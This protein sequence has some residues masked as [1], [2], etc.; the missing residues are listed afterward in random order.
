MPV[1]SYHDNLTG[2]SLLAPLPYP[3]PAI[4]YLLSDATA[5]TEPKA[6][7]QASPLIKIS[8]E[9]VDGDDNPVSNGRLSIGDMGNFM[10]AVLAKSVEGSP[11]KYEFMFPRDE[12]TGDLK[13]RRSMGE[14]AFYQ[15]NRNHPPVAAEAIVLG[16][17]QEDLPTIRVVVRK[18]AVLIVKAR[19][20]DGNEPAAQ[21]HVY[22][23]YGSGTKNRIEAAG[24]ANRDPRAHFTPPQMI[25]TYPA[26]QTWNPTFPHLVPGEP[27][28]L[29]VRSD[30]YTA[31][32]RTI[33]LKDGEK[34]TVELLIR[35]I[36][37]R[38]Q[39]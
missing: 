17:A 35:R 37:D 30:D 20:E 36:D 6:V 1:R 18:A 33:T 28:D 26:N 32:P 15:L 12:Y 25:H 39:P 24:R 38:E 2:D 31:E 19:T 23:S 3:I 10:N 11:G 14:A 27:I 34:R 7:I 16:K 9:V 22:A 5:S 8:V 4:D 13:F 21:V 29:T